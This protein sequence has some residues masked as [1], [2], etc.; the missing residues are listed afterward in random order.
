MSHQLTKQQRRVI[1]DAIG[2][3]VNE[4]GQ[5]WRDLYSNPTIQNASLVA[6]KLQKQMEYL[7]SAITVSSH[8]I[9]SQDPLYPGGPVFM[10]RNKTELERDIEDRV[11]DEI[12]VS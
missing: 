9:F 10:K 4:A 8:A 1:A 3:I 11:K 6:G 12:S 2:L 5:A 7:N